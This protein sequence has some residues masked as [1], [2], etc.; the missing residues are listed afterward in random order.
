MQVRIAYP[1]PERWQRQRGSRRSIM[2]GR[3]L[4]LGLDAL[5]TQ[6]IAERS[7]AAARS[8]VLFGSWPGHSRTGMTRIGA[9][10]LWKKKP[11]KAAICSGGLRRISAPS[12]LNTTL[13]TPD[14]ITC[15]DAVS[16]LMSSRTLSV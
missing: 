1:P 6:M 3:A 13:R 14:F 8:N 10:A 11:P 5:K 9:P 16:Q 12:Q 2:G 7:G 15:A 4:A